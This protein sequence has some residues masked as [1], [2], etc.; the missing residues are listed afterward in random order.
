M[1]YPV[2]SS[3]GGDGAEERL[4]QKGEDVEP[5]GGTELAHAAPEVDGDEDHRAQANGA[6]RRPLA[7]PVLVLSRAEQKGDEHECVLVGPRLPAVLVED[8]EG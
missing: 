2:G 5:E 8:G 3:Q 6:H 1:A 7:I 4:E